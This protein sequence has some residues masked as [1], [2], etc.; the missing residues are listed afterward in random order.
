METDFEDQAI[1][2]P[3][4][5]DGDTPEPEFYEENDLMPKIMV[6]RRQREI[7]DLEVIPEETSET[8]WS[9]NTRSQRGA[10]MQ[11]GNITPGL[12]QSPQ[13]SDA[14]SSSFDRQDGDQENESRSACDTEELSSSLTVQQMQRMQ[15]K[16]NDNQDSEEF[17]E[18]DGIDHQK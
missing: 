7:R 14:Q 4:L 13:E 5:W 15:S 6:R 10:A 8:D 11:D 3:P 17:K 1:E 18:A 16:F 12:G 2:I 9:G